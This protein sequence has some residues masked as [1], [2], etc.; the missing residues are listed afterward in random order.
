MCFKQTN[1]RSSHTLNYSSIAS[2]VLMTSINPDVS[3]RNTGRAIVFHIVFMLIVSLVEIAQ[4]V[5]GISIGSAI[6]DNQ[7][8]RIVLISTYMECLGSGTMK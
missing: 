1:E 5:S 3:N 8:N 4:V 6:R 2:R 7:D